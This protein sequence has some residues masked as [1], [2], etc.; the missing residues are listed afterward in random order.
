VRGA[1]TEAT[2]GSECKESIEGP[3]REKKRAVT[4]GADPRAREASLIKVFTDGRRSV[5]P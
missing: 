5:R 4:R 2:V 1:K 3:G